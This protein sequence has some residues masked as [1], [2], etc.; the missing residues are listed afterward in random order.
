MVIPILFCIYVDDLLVNL[1]QIGIGRY[2]DGTFVGAIAHANNIVLI[3][4]TSLSMRKLL[5]T[6]DSCANEF[7]ILLNAGE[8]KF[9]SLHSGRTVKR[10]Q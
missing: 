1:S 4:P 3:N 8:S 6:C 7:D 10:V 5:F 2:I 9:F